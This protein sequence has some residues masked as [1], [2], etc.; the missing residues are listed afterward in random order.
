MGRA[1]GSIV[2]RRATQRLQQGNACGAEPLHVGIVD[3]K[4]QDV[5]LGQGLCHIGLRFSEAAQEFM[6]R[7]TV[8]H[9][10]KAYGVRGPSVPG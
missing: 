10:L 8:A 3:V 1:C 6:V 9:G 5:C 7:D 4:V 2:P